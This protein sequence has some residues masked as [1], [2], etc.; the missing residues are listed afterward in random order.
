MEMP[1]TISI[2]NAALRPTS[3]LR[4]AAPYAN[5]CLLPQPLKQIP[6]NVSPAVDKTKD[7]YKRPLAPEYE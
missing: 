7:A 4:I 2:T 5:V 3:L 6:L 1:A